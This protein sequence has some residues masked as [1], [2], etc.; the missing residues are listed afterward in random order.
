M[1]KIIAVLFLLKTGTVKWKWPCLVFYDRHPQAL[2]GG[3]THYLS[4]SPVEGSG[5]AYYG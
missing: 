4:N 5:A 1:S 2:L 3:A